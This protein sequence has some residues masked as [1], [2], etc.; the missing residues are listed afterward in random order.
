L[1]YLVRHNP[2]YQDVSIDHSTV[3]SWADDFDPAE[4]QDHIICVNDT[5]YHERAGYAV[6]LENCNY[7]NDWQV[8]EDDGSDPA[9][10]APLPPGSATTDINGERQNPDMRIL[11]SVYY[12]VNSASQDDTRITAMS[13]DEQ[14]DKV[15]RAPQ[16]TPVINTGYEVKLPC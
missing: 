4:I 7:E 11:S 8:A 13:Y 16:T 5:D 10:G 12:L 6:D 3:D 2:L 14:R 1:Q 15:L 9:G